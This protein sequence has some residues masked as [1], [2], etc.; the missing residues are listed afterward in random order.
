MLIE[1]SVSNFKSIKE[2]K[3][4]KLASSKKFSSNEL[5]DNITLPDEFYKVSIVKSAVL[6]G[7]N[8]SGKS[9]MLKAIQALSFLV[10][11]S[12]NFKL[13]EKI[14]LYS[15]FKLSAKNKANPTNFNILFIAKN[16]IK[17]FYNIE[18]NATQFLKEELYFYPQTEKPRK[19]L[20]FR[21]TLGEQTEFGTYYEGTKVIEV[22]DNQLILSQVATRPIKSLIA[23]F[24][25]FSK[26]LFCSTIHDTRYDD[27]IIQSFTKLLNEQSSAFKAN[28]NKLIRAADTGILEIRTKEHKEEAFKFPEDIPQ[29]VKEE[30]IERF[31]HRIKTVHNV[32]ED[33]NEN[34]KIIGEELFD[35]TEE[36]TGTIKLLVVGG[37]I[38]DA[39][40]YGSTIIIDEL[41]KS[42]HPLVS[43]MLIQL[44]NSPENNPNNAQLIFATHDISLINRNLFRLDQI[45]FAEKDFKGISNYYRLSDFTNLSKVAPLSKWYLLG[46]FG[47]TP[48]IDEYE[49][50]LDL[51]N[52][53]KY[54]SQQVH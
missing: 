49:L 8:A 53:E 32:Y 14:E 51:D 15:P 37:L 11:H 33:G 24:R 45:Y 43:A 39:L 4:L 22:Y 16:N 18:F 17:Y 31:R 25:F 27:A 36:S 54:E 10:E 23:P 13:D 30:L 52:V 12:M 28:I 3:S 9:N 20:V 2:S 19:T 21:R 6:F 41:D 5:E 35:I 44:F 34:E 46:R 47:A 29:K 26:Y 48:M 42:L 7:G 40:E 38:L 50:S 1:F